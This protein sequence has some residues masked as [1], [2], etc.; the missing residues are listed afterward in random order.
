MDCARVLLC[1]QDARS[2]LFS[3]PSPLPYY[4][5]FILGSNLLIL[6]YFYKN[7]GIQPAFR[8]IFDGIDYFL[9]QLFGLNL[10]KI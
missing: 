2:A 7:S 10:S 1:P 4:F 3:L 6:L 5:S 9:S 8:R